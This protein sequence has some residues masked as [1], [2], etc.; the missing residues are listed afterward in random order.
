MRDDPSTERVITVDSTSRTFDFVGD[1]HDLSSRQLG[2]FTV[3][4]GFIFQVRAVSVSMT[5]T[6]RG[7]THTVT[8]PSGSQTGIKVEPIDGVPF[9]V[10][11]GERT[12]ARIV[13]NPFEQLLRNRG[14]GFKMKPVLVAEHVSLQELSP[15]LLDRIVVRFNDGVTR[16]RID[17]IN[18]ER[19]LTVLDF[20]GPTNYFV[21]HL[22]TTITLD[23]ALRFYAGKSEVQFTLPDNIVFYRQAAC[24]AGAVC[25]CDPNFQNPGPFTQVNAPQAWSV[26]Q[27]N[28]R[29]ALLA[30]IDNS[31]DLT[32]PDMINNYFINQGELLG[33]AAF[34]ANRDGTVT[35]AEVA[36]FDTDGDGLITFVD[37]NAP[38]PA[39]IAG[40]CPAGRNPTPPTCDPLDLVDGLSGN[41]GFEDGRDNDRNGRDDDLVGWDFQNN[42]NLVHTPG[43]TGCGPAH[44]VGVAGIVA[45][46]G[47]PPPVPPAVCSSGLVAGM[48]WVGRLLPIINGGGT[49]NTAT[50]SAGYLSIRYAVALGADAINASWGVTYAQGADPGCG[51]SIPNLGSK[52]TNT[53]VP[54]VNREGTSLA[55]GNTVLVA[56]VD[57]CAQNDDDANILDWPP[58]LNNTNIIAV[59]GI[60]TN[61]APSTLSPNVAFG[62]NTVDI[63]APSQNHV[64]LNFGGGTNTC[65]GTSYATPM[66]TGTIGLLLARNA[67]PPIRGN[68]ATV[69]SRILCNATLVPGLATQVGGGGRVLNVNASVTNA[70]GCP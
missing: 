13:F 43:V 67:N 46:I 66:V 62:P 58:G 61:V 60:Q 27:G 31:F 69:L 16:D 63:V 2:F 21:L 1:L 38:P 8:V 52:F 53:I 42:D 64:V 47:A 48:N 44:G 49:T 70:N 24:P 4:A 65:T 41:V 40:I 18:A 33:V 15:I 20:D 34:D 50:R 19:G 10:R 22:P 14:Q 36:G 55:L 3:P 5:I 51:L 30:V 54:A 12:G 28:R 45:A 26:T 56:A 6:L 25:P 23:D 57:N 9:E 17:Q 7:E 29:T 59:S 11:D 39:R 37:L 32:N 35:A 68:A